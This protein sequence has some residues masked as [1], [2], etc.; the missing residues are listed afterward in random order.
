MNEH[1]PGSP[2][3]YVCWGPH[4]SWCWLSGWWSS[5]WEVSG[6]QINW[7]CLSSY[8]IT[9]LLIF[10]QPSLIQQRGSA[11]SVHW[12]GTNI[13]IWFFQL[14]CWVFQR[15]VMIYPFLW[16]LH[17][18]SNSVRPFLNRNSKTHDQELINGISWNWKATMRQ[19]TYSIR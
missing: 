6:V 3:L 9:L 4:I 16:V 2:L 13:S 19:R 12:L 11:V 5:V 18:V 8:S 17:S 15:A 7:D 14:L 1:R 10:F